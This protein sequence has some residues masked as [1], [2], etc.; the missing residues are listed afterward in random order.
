MI[1]SSTDLSK[2]FVFR[3]Y[4]YILAIKFVRELINFGVGEVCSNFGPPY[5]CNVYLVMELKAI[6]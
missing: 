5:G 2:I 3:L 1:C 6:M 4:V